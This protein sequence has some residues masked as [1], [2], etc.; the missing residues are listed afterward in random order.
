MK[1]IAPFYDL[2]EM[3]NY[4]VVLYDIVW[5]GGRL[6]VETSNKAILYL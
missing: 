6:G 1:S 3:K 5:Y 2:Q 4:V